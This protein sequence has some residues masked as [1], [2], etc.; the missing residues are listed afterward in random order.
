[1]FELTWSAERE[2]KHLFSFAA[3]PAEDFTDPKRLTQKGA[4]TMHRKGRNLRE[5]LV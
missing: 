2:S 1:M 3:D 5:Y 4:E